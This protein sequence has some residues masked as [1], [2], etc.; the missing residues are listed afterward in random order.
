MKFDRI[1]HLA[2]QALNEATFRN[3]PGGNGTRKPSGGRDTLDDVAKRNRRSR[4]RRKWKYTTVDRSS[5]M[6]WYVIGVDQNG[7]K[8]HLSG[9][10]TNSRAAEAWRKEN[11]YS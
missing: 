4:A 10:F 7:K 5:N 11:G 8:H 2:E 9:G 6:K 3:V 1:H